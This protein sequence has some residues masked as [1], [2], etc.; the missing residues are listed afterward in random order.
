MGLSTAMAF[1]FCIFSP[2]RQDWW[3]QASEKLSRR[4]ACLAR[5]EPWVPSPALHKPDMVAHT[6]NP[7]T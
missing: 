3:E 5:M 7:S 4:G 2:V 6:W 1:L